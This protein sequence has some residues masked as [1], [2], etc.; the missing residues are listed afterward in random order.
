MGGYVR[1]VTGRLSGA[2][3][4]FLLWGPCH[5]AVL[6][7]AHAPDSPW[8]YAPLVSVLYA[9]AGCGLGWLRGW[10][11]ASALAIAV[12]LSSTAAIRRIADDPLGAHTQ[13]NAERRQ[14]AESILGD[15]VKHHRAAAHVLAF[16]VGYLGWAIPGRVDDLLGLVAPGW[17]PCLRGEDPD[18]VMSRLHPD[19]VVIVD[20]AEY[21]PTAC[22][23]HSARLREDYLRITSLARPWG[24]HYEVWAARAR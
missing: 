12:A 18:A 16:E 1:L 15:L 17:Q 22:I 13:W 7:V 21:R 6:T 20:A 10:F 2:N 14:L 23:L 5:L 11:G 9:A 24:Q 4:L 8:Y 19:Y 3:G